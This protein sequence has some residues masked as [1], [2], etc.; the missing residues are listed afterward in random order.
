MSARRRLRAAVCAVGLLVAC[1]RPN[2]GPPAVAAA[3]AVALEPLP[4]VAFAEARERLL[5]AVGPWRGAGARLWTEPR[6]VAAGASYRLRLEVQC[7]CAALVFAIDGSSDEIA[8]L[9]PNAYEPPRRLAAGEVREIPSSDRYALR[10]VGEGGLDVLKLFVT[11]G[12]FAFPPRGARA[13]AAT[14]GEPAAVAELAA[15]LA[16]LEGRAWAA[17]AT[18]LEI[19]R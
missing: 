10:A 1:T 11:P 18:P 13:W 12:D 17:V 16:G 8:L 7:D 2:D 6:P 3:P 19:G 15:F 4:R 9:Y 14:P 5:S